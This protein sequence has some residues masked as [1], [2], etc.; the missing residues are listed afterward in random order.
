MAAGICPHCMSVAGTEK[1]TKGWAWG[2]GIFGLLTSWLGFGVL[3]ILVAVLGGTARRCRT[4]KEDTKLVPLG[5]PRGQELL[6]RAALS[7]QQGVAALPP[8]TAR[9]AS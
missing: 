3:L 2:A 8:A 1:Y 5:T 4:C 7:G 6:G 9:D